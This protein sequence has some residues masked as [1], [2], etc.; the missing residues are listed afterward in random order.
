MEEN[1]ETGRQLKQIMV[2]QGITVVLVLLL[3]SITVVGQME[4]RKQMV[5][6][7]QEMD[8]YA[9]MRQTYEEEMKRYNERV[10][11]WQAAMTGSQQTTPASEK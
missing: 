10:K 4:Y 6:Y 1:K 7:Q 2:F 9:Q 5:R 3:T 11:Q 8:R